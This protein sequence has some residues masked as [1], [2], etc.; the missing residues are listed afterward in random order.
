MQGMGIE[1]PGMPISGVEQKKNAR[2]PE[3]SLKDLME[4]MKQ[5]NN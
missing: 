3:T 4:M 1:Q 2:F 5:Q